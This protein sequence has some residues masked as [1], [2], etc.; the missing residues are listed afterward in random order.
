[1]RFKGLLLYTVRHTGDALLRFSIALEPGGPV[2]AGIPYSDN[3]YKHGSFAAHFF[4]EAPLLKNLVQ[5]SRGHRV[6]AFGESERPRR[7]WRITRTK[8][9]PTASYGG[10]CA[11]GAFGQAAQLPATLPFPRAP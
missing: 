3:I 6:D 10:V 7:L 4:D 5:G 1:M 9:W 2:S 8:R 11:D